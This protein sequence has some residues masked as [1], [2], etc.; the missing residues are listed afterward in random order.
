[1]VAHA[2]D[3]APAGQT[4]AGETTRL[5]EVRVEGAQETMPYLPEV[6]D[7]AIYAG[8]KTSVVDLERIPPVINNNHRQAY[9]ELPGLLVSEMTIPSHVNINYRGLGDP[10]E[11]G[12]LL[13]LKDGLPISSDWFGYPTV[14]YSPPFESVQRVELIRGGSALLY[15]P[16]PGPVLNYVTSLPPRD[17]KLAFTTM[18]TA[19]TD[20]LYSTFTELAGTSGQ[21]GYLGNFHHREADGPRNNADYAVDTGDLKL[22]LQQTEQS[23]WLF[24]FY[25]YESESGEAGR[26]TRAQYYTD[27]DLTTRPHDRLWIERHVPSLT[28]ENDLSEDT[29]LAVKSWGGYQD[30]FSRRQN[31]AGTL[32]NLDRR[33]FFF[34]GADARIRHHWEAWDNQHTLTGGFV[35]YGSDNPRE[36]ERSTD[37]I[38]TSGTDRFEMD[39]STL[40]GSFFAENRFQF[41][42]FAVIPAVRVEMIEMESTENYNVEVTRPLQDERYRDTVPLV[43]LGLTYDV[44]Q[45]DQLYANVSQGY[46][47][48]QYDDL[49]NPTSNTQRPSSDLAVG[50]TWTHELGIRGKPTPWFFYDTSLFYIDWDNRIETSTLAGG[51]VER[52]NSGRAEFYGWEAMV[53]ADVIGLIDQCAGTKHGERFGSLSL[54]GNVSLLEAQF[55]RGGNK[56]QEPA[57]APEYILKTGAIWRWKNRAKLA[58]TGVF[59]ADHHWQD[60]NLPGTVGTDEVAPYMVWDL[61][62]EVRLYKDIVSIVG[63]INNLLDE[64]YYSRIRSDGID[65]APRRNFY[66]GVKVTF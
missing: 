57:Y 31:A 21:F 30:R 4:A 61:T 44:T 14:Y 38:A 6:K 42:R 47:P 2:A 62:A 52:S 33:E 41:G 5:P 40:Y 66:G 9:A 13:T 48:P 64:D 18:H 60:S 51:N 59:V 36:R 16:Q 3:S 24:G 1:L 63:G 32:T 34:G 27:R 10:H 45:N 19:G 22:I 65:P 8:K 49:V 35:V 25:G 43:G 56:G 20:G 58:L 46:Q 29:L 54:F 50:Q 55:I 11:S 39:N 23:R 53:A 17:K 12:F 15:G 28:Y 26:L 37:L 7:T